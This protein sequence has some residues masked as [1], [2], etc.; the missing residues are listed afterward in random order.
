MAPDCL[1]RFKGFTFNLR[2]KM[3]TTL[4]TNEMIWIL[5]QIK[6]NNKNKEIV[7]KIETAVWCMGKNDFVTI[8]TTRI[9]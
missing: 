5:N 8:E 7:D 2:Q 3:K 4:T 1:I 6:S 9:K